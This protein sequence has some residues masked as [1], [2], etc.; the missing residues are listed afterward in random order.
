MAPLVLHPFVTSRYPARHS[1]HAPLNWL[2]VELTNVLDLPLNNELDRIR[3]WFG[4][5]PGVGDPGFQVF[6]LDDNAYG[7][8]SET[9]ASFWLMGERRAE[10]LLRSDDPRRLLRLSLRA[11]AVDTVVTAGIGGKEI[12]IP[13]AAG[14]QADV[15][16]V[17]PPG[18]PNKHARP[19]VTPGPTYIWVLSLESSAGFRPADVEPGSTDTRMLG[20]HVRPMVLR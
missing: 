4:E 14:T 6:F 13:V 3:Q 1:K 12:D 8:E 10:L 11:G 15:V 5:N 2:P 17:L 9:D 20:V 18:F 16:M 19:V 7:K